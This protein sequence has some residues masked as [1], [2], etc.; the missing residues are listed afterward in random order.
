[1][2]MTFLKVESV[3]A[4][5]HER[6]LKMDVNILRRLRSK[7]SQHFAKFVCAGKTDRV[8]Y[9]VTSLVGPNINDLKRKCKGRFKPRSV[10]HVAIGSLE[11]LR[12]MHEIK[13]VLRFIP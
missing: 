1:M 8:H 5:D 9:M 4:P 2:T 12:D 3:K 11:G 6:V 13:R 10:A 7:Q